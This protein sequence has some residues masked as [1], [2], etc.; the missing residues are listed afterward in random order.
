ML[1]DRGE[2]IGIAHLDLL[3]RGLL[4]EDLGVDLLVDELPRELHLRCR[5]GR[6]LH[7]GGPALV[8]LGEDLV[9]S[10]RPV[11]DDRDDAVH[12]DRRVGAGSR[13]RRISFR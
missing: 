6:D 12:E 10:D 2:E 13:L 9:P 7:A 1:I 4:H 11:A 8:D 5:V 3:G